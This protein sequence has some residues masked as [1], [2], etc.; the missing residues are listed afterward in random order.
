MSKD[1]P[2]QVPQPHVYGNFRD[3]EWKKPPSRQHRREG[4]DSKH[5]RFV[6]T[7][8]CCVCG[9]MF[10]VEGHHLK[11]DTHERGMGMKA[12]DRFL[13][14]LCGGPLGHHTQIEA[15][16][17]T[18]EIEQFIDWGIDEV[19]MLAKRLCMASG[20]PDQCWRILIEHNRFAIQ[21]WG[22]DRPIL[23]A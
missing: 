10:C 9:S 19:Q 13:V 17:S 15:I 18:R 23:I 20:N 2:Q 5:R 1:W 3:P 8:P 7:L 14:P 6:P 21:V 11:Q 22:N 16:G 12:T 4:N